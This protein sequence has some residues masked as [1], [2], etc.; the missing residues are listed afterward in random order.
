[1]YKL[2]NLIVLMA[3][4]F[5]LSAQTITNFTTSDGL[6]DNDVTCLVHDGTGVMWFGTQN[7]VVSYDGVSWN[8]YNTTTDSNFLQ[9]AVTAI[10]IGSGG[11]IWIGTDAGA[12]VFDGTVWK[13]FTTADGLGNNRI[14]HIAKMVNGDIW[15][16]E[17]S[18]ATKYDGTSFTSYDNTDGL[19]FGG[20]EYISEDNNGDILLCTGL[21]GLISYDGTSFKA[22]STNEGLVSKNTS[23]VALD[24]DGNKWIGTAAGV[25]VLSASNQWVE[26]HTQMLKIPEPDTLNPVEDIVIDDLGNVWVGIYVDY[27]V[28]VGG[29][30]MYDGTT[31]TT[32]DAS[33]GLVGP[34]VRKIALDGRGNL[35]VGTSSG[36]S[37][38]SN[39]TSTILEI[40][41]QKNR[42]VLYPNPATNNVSLSLSET[43]NS[44]VK[45]TIYNTQF[46]VVLQ[47]DLTSDGECDIDIS[48]LSEGIYFVEVEGQIQKL[49]VLNR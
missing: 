45:A 26:N 49:E 35:W 37:R 23:S 47:S 9:D 8:V 27:L 38:I 31:W 34:T 3:W 36:I 19:P 11:E 5:S 2:I 13:S 39:S 22:Y 20:V 12:S 16:G 28:T 25:T 18:G 40:A 7:G 33:D 30:A 41:D 42:L 32:I 17:F 44:P 21:G 43:I 15:F 46:Q 14:N 4:G 29:V 1:M 6:P 24:K 10:E 48:T